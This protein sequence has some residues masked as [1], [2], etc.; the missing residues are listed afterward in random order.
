MNRGVKSL[1]PILYNTVPLEYSYCNNFILYTIQ[2]TL[3]TKT[4][5]QEALLLAIV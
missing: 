5:T 1:T 2:Y 4:H 3:H